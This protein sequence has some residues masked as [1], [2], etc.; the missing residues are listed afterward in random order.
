M[1]N[2][3]K[4]YSST[5]TIYNPMSL[6][7]NDKRISLYDNVPAPK[8]VDKKMLNQLTKYPGEDEDIRRISQM[9]RRNKVAQHYKKCFCKIENAF[10]RFDLIHIFIL[11]TE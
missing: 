10:L 6:D 2:F 3:L 5:S 1:E 7:T 11:K 4:R 8:T 9:L